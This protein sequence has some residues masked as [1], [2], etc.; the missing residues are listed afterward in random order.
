MRPERAG[1]GGAGRTGRPAVAGTSECTP[2]FNK[3]LGDR[4]IRIHS[5]ISLI[6][7]TAGIHIQFDFPRDK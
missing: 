3:L 2:L 7:D 6:I 1:F 5:A 4:M